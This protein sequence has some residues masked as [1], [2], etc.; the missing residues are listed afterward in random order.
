MG[1]AAEETHKSP[2]SNHSDPYNS[3]SG[4]EIVRTTRAVQSDEA[5]TQAVPHQYSL[6]KSQEAGTIGGVSANII[7]H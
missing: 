6:D 3:S 5:Y 1:Q 7:R 4:G 2:V